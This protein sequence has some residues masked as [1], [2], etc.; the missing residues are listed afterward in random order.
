MTT[1]RGK[2]AHDALGR[3]RSHV[4]VGPDATAGPRKRPPQV[5]VRARADPIGTRGGVGE[6][7]APPRLSQG[8]RWLAGACGAP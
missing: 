6:A 2:I 5:L 3:D 8:I 4:V 7:K 1:K